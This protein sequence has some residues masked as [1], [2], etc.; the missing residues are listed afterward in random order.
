MTAA[1]PLTLADG[2]RLADLIDEPA[3]AVSARVLMDPEIFAWE[4][5]RIWGK[6]WVFVAHA[7][8]LPRP[9]DFVARRIGLDNVIVVRDDD[10]SIHVLLNVCSHR[11][12]QLCHAEQGSASRFQCPYHGWVYDRRG[13]MT[14]APAE[15]KMY[16]GGLDHSQLGLPA[17]QVGVRH[18]LV[19]A[20]WSASGPGLA[21]SLGDFAFYV[22]M[23]FGLT[24]GGWE[25][26]GP[27]QRWR[28]PVNWKIPAENFSG[29]A[30]HSIVT[31]RS[32]EQAGRVPPGTMMKSQQGV[33]VCDP[34]WGHGGRCT[35]LRGSSAATAAEVSR[36]FGRILP[37][38][39]PGLHPQIEQHLT[40]DQLE[41][42]RSGAAPFLGSIFPNLA[43]LSASFPRRPGAPLEPGVTI[44]TWVPLDA[45]TIEF[46]SWA[47]VQADA[48]AE[49]KA[50]G[51]RAIAYTFGSSGTLEQDDTEA[52]AQIQRSVAGA[53]GRRR[54]IRYNASAEPDL[55]DD[56]TGKKWGGPGEVRTGF[57][58]DDNQWN[59][60][61]RWLAMITAGDA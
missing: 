39:P 40:G 25:V 34:A 5:D 41:L 59:W 33:A 50:R 61:R 20:R 29:D 32:E 48:D 30:Y 37:A 17:A 27:P 9:G 60:W 14:G 16:R 3:R 52:W 57:G 23:Y 38:I 58:S 2:T 18:G 36:L 22:D 49:I 53:Q 55:L 47:L 44:R 7:T 13:R 35:P 54:W 1:G 8:E 19:F 15:R 28:I 43:F 21:E 10:D 4:Q 46:M 6:S 11:A 45:N 31:H 26:A 42:L 12:A 51:R 56:A 24:D